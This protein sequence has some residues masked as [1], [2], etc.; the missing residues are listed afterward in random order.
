MADGNNN[1]NP[2]EI[3]Y[4]DKGARPRTTQRQPSKEES[5]TN[6]DEL[7]QWGDE[8][9]ESVGENNPDNAK[10]IDPDVQSIGDLSIAEIDRRLEALNRQRTAT[11]REINRLNRQNAGPRFNP[12]INNRPNVE[13]NDSVISSGSERFNSGELSSGDYNPTVD[14]VNN[15]AKIVRDPNKNRKRHVSSFSDGFAIGDDEER[16]LRSH[17]N[18]AQEIYK[19][20]YARREHAKENNAS[21]VEIEQ[22]NQ[23]FVSARDNFFMIKKTILVCDGQDPS[24]RNDAGP[25]AWDTRV[26][27]ALSRVG[28]HIY[29][30]ING[31]IAPPEP[32][33]DPMMAEASARMAE[34]Q[35]AAQDQDPLAELGAVGGISIEEP[36]VQLRNNN[37]N[38]QNPNRRNA[39]YDDNL[40]AGL[41][42]QIGVVDSNRRN[43]PSRPPSSNRSSSVSSIDIG[44][45]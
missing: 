13:R 10:N 6:S 35:Q 42:D 26:S 3:N 38:R 4:K 21:N 18:S 29:N 8:L 2:K 15:D 34:M 28:D 31:T 43:N 19:K 9:M 36:S 44:A 37:S 45:I 16:T 30:G 32:E 23:A 22:V 14:L 11:L 1:N 7:Q 40:L 12:N 33:R 41:S 25:G 39:M 17:H 27:G 5:E 24:M 20:A